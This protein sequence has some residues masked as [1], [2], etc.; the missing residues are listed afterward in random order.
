[1]SDLQKEA[2]DR[3][4]ELCARFKETIVAHFKKYGLC[5][6]TITDILM[7]MHINTFE[8]FASMDEYAKRFEKK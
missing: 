5:Q 7:A 2:G 4:Q 8:M 6:A 1:M 3:M